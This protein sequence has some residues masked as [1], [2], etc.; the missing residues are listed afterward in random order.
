ML[1]LFVQRM[2]VSNIVQCARGHVVCSD[3]RPNVSTCPQVR[4]KFTCP[5]VSQN[6]RGVTFF[7]LYA[8]WVFPETEGNLPKQFFFVYMGQKDED[9][10]CAE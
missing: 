4:Q 9:G 7:C 1:A 5:E 3:C 2:I 6:V 10:Y 8:S